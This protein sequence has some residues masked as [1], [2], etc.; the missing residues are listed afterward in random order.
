MV[1]WYLHDLFREAARLGQR[2]SFEEDG[3]VGGPRPGP[4]VGTKGHEMRQC[5]AQLD[6]AVNLVSARACGTRDGMWHFDATF[7]IPTVGTEFKPYGQ[8][9]KEHLL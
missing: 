2:S 4:T 3:N 1:P 5:L 8:R 9:L 7:A 6:L